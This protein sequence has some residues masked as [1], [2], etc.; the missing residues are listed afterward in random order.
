M[1]STCF[2]S[3]PDS[4]LSFDFGPD[5]PST[6]CPKFHGSL[7][8]KQGFIE[9]S[10]TFACFEAQIMSFLPQVLPF[11]PQVSP[12]GNSCL[13][14]PSLAVGSIDDCNGEFCL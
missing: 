3:T 6:C 7:A 11:L 13:Q 8:A 14:A 12:P 10:K 9:L 4:C 5:S 1:S 2:C